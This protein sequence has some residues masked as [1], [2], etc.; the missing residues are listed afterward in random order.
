[1][2]VVFD[3]YC[4]ENNTKVVEHKLRALRT[5][6]ADINFTSDMKSKITQH[7]F[8]A[9]NK[10]KT[11]FIKGLTKCM[12][13]NHR[14]DILEAPRDADTLIVNTAVELAQ[15]HPNIMIAGTDSF[16]ILHC[17]QDTNAFFHKP[18]TQQM[19]EETICIHK[20]QDKMNPTK[21]FLFFARSWWLRYYIST[22]W[23]GEEE[24]SYNA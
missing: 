19:R 18:G 14:M 16:L 20:C 17:K 7:S 10:N 4:E 23:P 24:S 11:R 5:Q 22:I 8:L 3:G 13:E 2:V 12:V 1:M 6:S 9:N 15:T 21:Y